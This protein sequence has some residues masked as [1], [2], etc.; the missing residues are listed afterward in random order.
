MCIR[1]RSQFQYVHARFDGRQFDDARQYAV[2]AVEGEACAVAYV[3]VIGSGPL[4]E[5]LLQVV[6]VHC[7]KN[8]LRIYTEGTDEERLY[9]FFIRSVRNYP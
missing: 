5:L 3:G 2:V 4:V 1:D 9:P 6:F 7:F 8:W